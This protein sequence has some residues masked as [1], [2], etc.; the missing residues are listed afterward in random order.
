VLAGGKFISPVPLL[1]ALGAGLGLLAIATTLVNTFDT[2]HCFH[3]HACILARALFDCL[4]QVDILALSVL[5]SKNL[6]KA[7]KVKRV[8][9]RGEVIEM[10]T[11]PAGYAPMIDKGQ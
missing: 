7:H 10:D 1:T 5:P 11:A 8:D 2:M 3:N 9:E 4:F 6:Y